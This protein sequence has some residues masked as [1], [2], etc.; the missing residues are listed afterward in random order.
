MRAWL[1]GIPPDPA[2]RLT[3]RARDAATRSSRLWLPGIGLGLL[4][5]VALV[6]L[7]SESPAADFIYLVTTLL[8][9]VV[10][11]GQALTAPR[12]ARGP[13]WAF[14]MFSSLEMAAQGV[15]AVEAR[16][17]L[18]STFPG[19][20]DALSLA[21]Y[22]PAF[23]GIALLIHRLRPGLDRESWIDASI[24]T[25]TGICVFG[26]FLIAPAVTAALDGWAGLVVVLYPMLDLALLSCLIWLLVGHGRP[27]G[28]L[29]LL[30]ASFTLTL[31]ANVGRD[32]DLARDVTEPLPDWQGI[33]RVA[34]LVMMAAAAASPT[35]DVIA[36]PRSRSVARVTTPRLAL[37]ALGVLTVPTLLVFRVWREGGDATVLL[38]L[39]AMIIIILAVWRIQV[40]VS[41][42]EQQRRVTELVL[43]SAG[44]G[45]VGLDR[46][47][48]VLFA[49]LAARRMLRCRESDLLGRRFHDIAHHEHADGTPYPWQE[50][51]VSALVTSGEPAF[52]PDQRYVSRDGTA[53][54]VEIVMSPLIVEGA[55]MGAVQSFR[56]VSER[57]E[58][59]EIKRQFVS[60][61]SH[62]LRTPLTSI[63]GSLQMLDS[64][65]MGPLSDEQ[66]E[67]VSMAVANSERLG[68]LVNDILDLERL[69][70]G[71]M[72]L[73]PVEVSALALAQD[74][75]NGITGAAHAA[76]IRLAVE[77]PVDGA[78]VD[79]V[80][81][82]HRMI[83]VLTNLLGNA[84]KFSERGST[85]LVQVARVDDAVSIGVVD[86]GRGIPEDQLASVFE[87]FG[88]VDSG[89][90]RR[91]SGTGLGLA[92][93][94][95]IVERSGGTIA[96]ESVLGEG[97]TF[98][99]TIP[100][101]P[102][103]AIPQ[104]AT[105]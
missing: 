58:M 30:A 18:E 68:Q 99:V 105:P 70:A 40:L 17:G 55:V 36:D 101:A 13:W 54:P 95:E 22:L 5:I 21:A 28:A 14:F 96:V 15:A 87:R 11:F 12:G 24:L 81:D 9:L 49:N 74:S 88:Q 80:V 67:L 103:P 91:G 76:G 47:G 75:I 64:G 66:Q 53:F 1:F 46:E 77:P 78:C 27:S 23:V 50:C 89:D 3:D 26:L 25:V 33:V 16:G 20:V 35:A 102:T 57:L 104:E 73:T 86:R 38:A 4:A 97:S 42:V 56:D 94:R 2:R 34:A 29:I 48:F 84:I 79:V 92:I 61:V 85:I 7:P 65:F 39:A 32:A 44:D 69:D 8:S 62:E 71:R 52:L 51:P 59:D 100:A 72:P 60:V 93:A 90:A 31:A 82:P 83:Q 98:I 63:K 37:L 6:V 41:T 43:D 45:I 19:I 10:I